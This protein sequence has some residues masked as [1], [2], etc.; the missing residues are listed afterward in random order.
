[1][2]F[3]DWM[4]IYRTYSSEE[5]NEEVTQLKK[6]LK[7]GYSGQGVGSVN[8]QRDLGML[9]SR[10]QAI[11]RIRNEQAN[12]GNSNVGQVDFGGGQWGDL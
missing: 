11:S 8:F 12:A 2:A 4:E 7:G 9:Q 1:M 10:L 3:T 5:L 6:D